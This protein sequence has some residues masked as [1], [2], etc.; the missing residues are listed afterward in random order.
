MVGGLTI[1]GTES[2]KILIRAKGPSMSSLLPGKK[3]LPNP[4][5]KVQK[6]NESTNKYETVLQ[7]W[8]YGDH[9]SFQ[10]YASE[11]TGND[12]EP[13]VVTTLEPGVYSIKVQDETSGE[14]GNVNLEI[15]EVSE[16]NSSSTFF[17]LS[18]R[19][20]IDDAPMVGG[21][22]I[23]GTESKK[24]LIRAKGPSMASLLPGK[25]LL[26]NPKIKVQKLNDSTN[27]YETVLQTWD[28]GDHTSFQE[29]A[30][31][32]TGNDVE[33]MVVTTL[34]PGVYSIKVQDETSGGK[35]NTNLEIYAID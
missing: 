26:A 31:E 6:L 28:Y 1:K 8:D 23:K 18:G 2:K 16:D 35:G 4:K 17:G 34:E 13:M 14:T 11:A 3:L 30:S 27:K 10:E 9:A 32:A 29:Y 25:Q 15:Y 12:V 20:F 24:V 21:L 7:T 22:T 5:I 33:P 19:A